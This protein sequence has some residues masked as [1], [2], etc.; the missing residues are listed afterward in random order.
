MQAD[1]SLRWEHMSEVRFLTLRL[2]YRWLPRKGQKHSGGGG[3]VCGGGGGGG[4]GGA[5]RRVTSYIWHSTDMRA[6]WPPFQRC[7]VYD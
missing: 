4:G 7:Q 3:C 5:G 6:E 2:L 1:L